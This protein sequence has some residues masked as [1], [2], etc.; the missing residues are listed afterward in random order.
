[1]IFLSSKSKY[2]RKDSK[3]KFKRHFSATNSQI[4]KRYITHTCQPYKIRKRDHP[5]PLTPVLG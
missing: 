2:E 4:L 1:M 5:S 3:E